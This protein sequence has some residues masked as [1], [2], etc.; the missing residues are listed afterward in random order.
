MVVLDTHAWIWWV[1]EPSRLGR[2]ARERSGPRADR[3]GAG[4]LLPRVAVLAAR[5]RISLDRPALEW[6]ND[7]LAQPGVD[8]LPLTA[9]VAVK[10]ADLPALAPSDPADRL[11]MA[12]AILESAPL[13]TRTIAFGRVPAS[14][15]S[16]VA[17]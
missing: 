17:F 9:A 13:V 11:I 5:G 6:L 16:V 4:D 3:G 12:T 14:K 15:R 7:A 2:G 8:L 10:A 1:S